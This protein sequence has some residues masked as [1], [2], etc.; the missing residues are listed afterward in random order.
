MTLNEMPP[1]MREMFK[2]LPPAGEQ[3]PVIERMRWM[4][5]FEAVCRIVFKDDVSFEIT[6]PPVETGD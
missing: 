5:A 1:V 3:W 6:L 4:S 2:M